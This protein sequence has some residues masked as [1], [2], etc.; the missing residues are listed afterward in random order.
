MNVETLRV[1]TLTDG[2]PMD[3]SPSWTPDG[4]YVVF[5]SDRD[6]PG[7]QSSLY[8]MDRVG[9]DV[10][11]LVRFTGGAGEPVFIQG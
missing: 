4:R 8:V 10:T 11:P 5:A 9:A 7:G 6:D 2:P 1:T 3:C